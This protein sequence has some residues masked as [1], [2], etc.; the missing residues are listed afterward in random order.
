MVA[1]LN[2][3]AR[4][5]S[6][7]SVGMRLPLLLRSSG[8][9][10]NILVLNAFMI[11]GLFL[12]EQVIGQRAVQAQ[13]VPAD[14]GGGGEPAPE[15]GGEGEPAPEGGG[16]GEPA[17]EEGGVGEP[18]SSPSP[19]PGPAPEPDPEPESCEPESESE[20]VSCEP[21]PESCEPESESEYES[22]EPEPGPDPVPGPKP[23]PTDQEVLSS[24]DEET[25]RRFGA[26]GLLPRNPDAAGRGMALYSN[27]LT[28]TLFERLPLRQFDP[29]EVVEEVVEEVTPE[30]EMQ[31]EVPVRALWSKNEVVSDQEAQRA[32]DQAIAQAEADFMLASSALEEEQITLEWNGT[33]Y[34]E[35]PS[36]ANQLAERDGWRAWVRGFGGN[37]HSDTDGI[38]YNDFSVTAFGVVAGADYSL[39]E[40]FQLG[41]FLNYGNVNIDQDGITGGGGWYPDGFG[42]GLTAEYWT[43]NFYVQSIVGLTWFDGTQY[44]NIID[45][46]GGDTARGSKSARTFTGGVRIGAPFR[47]GAVVLDPQAQI[48]GTQ[49][50]EDGFSETSGTSRDLRLKYRSRTT[51]FLETQLGLKLS[52]PIHSGDRAL[53]VPSIRAAWLGDWNQGNESQTIAYTFSDQTVDIPSNLETEHGALVEIGLDYTVQ[54]FDDA[55]IKVYGRGGVEFWGSERDTTWRASGGIIF[56]F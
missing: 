36:L 24:Y 47:W 23:G 1:G 17:P 44:R 54:N 31:E 38:V 16:G 25:L 34:L 28:Y 14:G 29:V 45:D 13:L 4:M 37:T 11:S 3:L 15:E 41:A 35:N 33:T 52:I 53:W 10:G 5:P 27:L 42:G 6:A 32:L 12:A 7:I 21:E 19:D 18:E 20:G 43:P 49:N 39:S 2:P 50:Q 51:N 8:L 46:F 22:C 26:S 48:V 56:Q 55:S 40:E 9:V 30:P